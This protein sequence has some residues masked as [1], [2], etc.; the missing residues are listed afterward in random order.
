MKRS[1]TLLVLS[2]GILL[3]CGGSEKMNKAPAPGTTHSSPN[4][5]DD[6]DLNDVDHPGHRDGSS[7]VDPGSG[8]ET[9]TPSITF[10][11]KNSGSSDLTLNMDK[12]WQ[13]VIFAYMGTPP[14]AKSMLM[15]P[16]H[17]TAS[18]DL[19]KADRCPYC[20]EPKR[21]V[22][23]K[24]AENHDEVKPGDMREV[25][26]DMMAFDYEKTQGTKNGRKNAAC[27]CYR[28]VTPAPGTYT[29]RACGL[30]KTKNA[31][32]RSEY[33]CVEGQIT[34]PVTE[35]TRVELDFQ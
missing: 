29:V 21:A 2:A 15:F 3:A 17:C 30:R 31:K 10:V 12:G 18:C 23:I 33:P 19:S 24:A 22:D 8:N 26:W 25:L 7:G 16:T 11:L 27:N 13:A 32:K 6:A 34:L 5:S 1:K 28:K 9:K 4:N 20:P 14:N 35:A